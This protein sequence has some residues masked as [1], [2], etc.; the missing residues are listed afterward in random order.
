VALA[1]L[2]VELPFVE[3]LRIEALGV[4]AVELCA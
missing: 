4:G 1:R 2:P 3:A